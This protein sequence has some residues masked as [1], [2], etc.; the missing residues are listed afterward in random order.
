MA[1][2]KATRAASMRAVGASRHH[3]SS[4]DTQYS[5]TGSEPEKENAKLVSIRELVAR[6]AAKDRPKLVVMDQSTLQSGKSGESRQSAVNNQLL[7]RKTSGRSIAASHAGAVSG[8]VTASPS[9]SASSSSASTPRTASQRHLQMPTTGG[10]STALNALNELLSKRQPPPSQSLANEVSAAS[11]QPTQRKRRG[12]DNAAVQ[13]LLAQRN[14]TA[15]GESIKSKSAANSES[16]SRAVAELLAKRVTPHPTSP[17]D[18]GA[19][20]ESDARKNAL[21]QMLSRRSGSG[22][23]PEPKAR[24]S[25]SDRSAPRPAPMANTEPAD[26]KSN[27][28]AEMLAKR[29]GSAREPK[30]KAPEP[31]KMVGSNAVA[32]MFARRAQSQ[33]ASK[34]ESRK[35]ALAD[36]LAKRGNNGDAS[37]P[38]KAEKSNP[39]AEML[40]KRQSPAPPS[41]PPAA[42]PKKSNPLAEMLARRQ[43]GGAAAETPKPTPVANPLAEMMAKRQ[44]AA[45]PAAPAAP[46]GAPA[47][48][49]AAAPAVPGDEHANTPLKDHPK[50]GSYFK[51][52]KIG[53][54]PDVVKHRMQREEV[55][56]AILDCDPSKPLPAVGTGGGEAKDTQDPEFLEALKQY[57][58]KVPKYQQMLKMGLPRGAVEQKMRMEGI[59]VAWLDGPPQPKTKAAPTGP[60]EA[61]IAAHREKY[62]QYFQMLKMGLPRGAV[63]HKMQMAGIDPKELD[64]PIVAGGGPAAASSSAPRRP[65]A[66]VI[67]KPTSIRKKI[68][69]EVKRQDTRDTTRESLWNLSIDEDSAGAMPV[70]ISKESKAMLEKL[71]VKEVAAKP[72]AGTAAAGA[73]GKKSAAKSAKKQVMYLIDMKKSQNIS[74]TLARIKLP[75]PELKSEIL[76]LNP[77]VLSTAQLQSLMD[78][79]PDQ[80]EQV[81]IDNF[82]GDDSLI[83]VA[84]KFLVEVRNIPRFKEKLG[85]LVFKQEFPTR[86]HELRESINLVIRGVNQVCC[87][88]ALQQLFIYIL[89]TGNLLNFGTDES[90]APTSVGGFAL[91]SL[92]KLSQTK[93]FT[94]GVTF[95]QYVVQSI[96]LDIPQLARFPQQINLIQKCSKVSISSLFSEKRAL[97]EGMKSLNHEAQ[98]RTICWALDAD[99]SLLTFL[100]I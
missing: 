71:F 91:N 28:L 36:M 2:G 52:L 68:H 55:D 27:A 39:L 13:A 44:A 14:G 65:P 60:T 29:S 53:L 58:A 94:G 6:N 70:R 42:A 23:A 93:A 1:S 31:K 90:D 7:S 69:W 3:S 97:E 19:N 56:P 77:T 46:A 4:E 20:P 63:E 72:A 11:P 73:D 41:A 34:D 12:A 88:T 48:A 37:A 50:Y 61:E 85:C 89:Q 30:P 66:P 45:A 92:V 5:D 33:S 54:S 35:N 15:M 51:M 75:F 40:A 21:A 43:G 98:V 96:E 74:I 22:H 83:G 76:A 81:A 24:A 59:D 62:K 67:K 49:P 57:N 32:D 26:P 87:S 47:G 80:Q 8:S 38:K 100:F 9:S 78:M 82:H 17:Q 95:L 99:I 16:R 84:E 25:G 10:G 86:V 18:G 64:G 79:W